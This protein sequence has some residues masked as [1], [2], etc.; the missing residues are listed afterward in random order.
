MQQVVEKHAQPTR[1]FGSELTTYEKLQL[2]NI[3]AHPSN[4]VNRG[5]AEVFLARHKGF[6]ELLKK[7]EANNVDI[8]SFRSIPDL[9]QRELNKLVYHQKISFD[10]YDMADEAIS[11]YSSIDEDLEI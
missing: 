10:F 1:D 11:V 8:A 6:I 3:K 2:I 9:I 4:S 5:E 7:P